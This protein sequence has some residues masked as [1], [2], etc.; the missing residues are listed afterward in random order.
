MLTI[1]E[2][3]AE[4]TAAGVEFLIAA[5]RL[6]DI[7]LDEVEAGPVR[8]C[9]QTMSVDLHCTLPQF[10][11]DDDSRSLMVRLEHVLECRSDD[12][13]AELVTTIRF[14][15]LMNFDLLKEIETS[16]A[17]V[18]A[19]IRTNV[20]FMAYP[21]VRQACSMLTVALGLPPVTLDYLHRDDWPEFSLEGAE[22]GVSPE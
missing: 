7:R 16:A 1:V 10:A 17:D 4:P 3:E 20:Y 12:E 14:C 13:D 18:A 11:W 5:T 15:H 21:Y 9:A 22:E 19:W 2:D 8:L 6:V